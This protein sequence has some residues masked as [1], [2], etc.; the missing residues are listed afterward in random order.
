MSR[1]SVVSSSSP[2]PGPELSLPEPELSSPSSLAAT[3]TGSAAGLP[4]ADDAQK[5]GVASPH[6]TIV[7]TANA[8]RGFDRWLGSAPPSS[9]SAMKARAPV[10][11]SC[12]GSILSS[13]VAEPAVGR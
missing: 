12:L 8:I 6:T 2:L 11:I 4:S 10:G 13:C 3:A 9:A 1:V 5:T 7:S